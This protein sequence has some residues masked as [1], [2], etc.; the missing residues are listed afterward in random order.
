MKK[1]AESGHPESNARLPSF[2]PPTSSIMSNLIKS[3]G[4]EPSGINVI[5]PGIQALKVSPDCPT[6]LYEI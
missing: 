6:P 3:E 1:I 2:E 4:Y 5:S